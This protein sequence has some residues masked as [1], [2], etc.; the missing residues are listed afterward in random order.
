MNGAS[1]LDDKLGHVAQNRQPCAFLT[2]GENRLAFLSAGDRHADPDRLTIVFLGGFRSNMRGQKA[3]HLAGWCES[4]GL[5][6]LRFDYSGHGESSGDFADGTVGQ[7]C[8]D[9]LSVIDQLAAGRVVLIGS[10]MG[11]WMAVLAA[12]ARP[13]KV[14][15]LMGI[16]AAPDFTEDLVPR[17]LTAGET[18]RLWREGRIER[19]SAYSEQPDVLTR[20]LLEEG[21]DHLVL[22]APLALD[23]PLR[24]IHGH[25]DPDVPVEQSR[26]LIEVWRGRDTKLIV[27]EDGDHRLS[28]P[29]DLARI[30]DLLLEL[31]IQVGF[32]VAK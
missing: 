9:A 10:S 14:V 1:S 22:R 11:A 21:R 12:L 16:A 23:C 13:E 25:A 7:W 6:F 28:R 24:L 15:G 18:D 30:S 27:I 4:R 2:S 29:S 19:P 26:R 20:A 8:D 5:G 17:R 3:E 32:P 31:L